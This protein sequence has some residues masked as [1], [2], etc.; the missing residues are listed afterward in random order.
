MADVY[1][2]AGKR[3]RRYFRSKPDAERFRVQ[4]LQA[5]AKADY[6]VEPS[7]EEFDALLLARNHGLDLGQVVASAV[8]AKG[9]ESAASPLTVSSVAADWLKALEAAG[10]S[11]SHR[12]RHSDSRIEFN[13][14]VQ[15]LAQLEAVNKQC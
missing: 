3:A 9:A 14:A 15:L 2:P 7:K 1:E 6:H 11:A 13:R 5:W 4:L 10:R 12:P 8:A